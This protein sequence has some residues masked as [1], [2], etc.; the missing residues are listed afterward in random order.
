MTTRLDKPIKREVE[1]DGAIY[2]VV[3][4]SD[5]VAIAPKGRRTRRSMTWKDL[6]SGDAELTRDLH[7][8]LD[9][10]KDE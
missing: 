4:S 7:V 10:F 3:I 1:I 5:G 6:V 8:S 9:A 2:T